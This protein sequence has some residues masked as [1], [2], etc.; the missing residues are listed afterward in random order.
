MSINRHF[1]REGKIMLGIFFGIIALGLCAAVLV[2]LLMPRSA[3]GNCIE[4]GG[5]FNEQGHTC[6][7]LQR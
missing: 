2:P 7:N 4:S 3:Q 5:T 6:E 1:S